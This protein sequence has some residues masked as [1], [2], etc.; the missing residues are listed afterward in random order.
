MWGL[1]PAVCT[2]SC[3]SWSSYNITPALSSDAAPRSC[4]CARRFPRAPALPRVPASRPQWGQFCLRLPG[5]PSVAGTIPHPPAFPA[6]PPAGTG[7]LPT[8]RPLA[9]SAPSGLRAHAS[10]SAAR[11]LLGRGKGKKKTTTKPTP[12]TQ[13]REVEGGRERKRERMTDCNPP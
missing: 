8:P 5:L 3:F 9:R 4:V 6:L 7:G 12:P 11:Q 13:P 10:G 2:A 1:R